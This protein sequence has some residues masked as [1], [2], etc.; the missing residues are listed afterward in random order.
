MEVPMRIVLTAALPALMTFPAAAGP[1]VPALARQLIH[2]GA[3][4]A[5]VGLYD[6]KAI[7]AVAGERIAGG[8]VTVETGDLWHIGSI[9]KSM[10]A[11]LAARM[12]ENGQIGWDSTLGDVLGP[13]VPGMDEGFRAAT[14]DQLLSHRAGVPENAGLVASMGFHGRRDG[15]DLI[16]ERLRYAGLV[17]HEAPLHPPGEGFLYSNAGYV[18]AG[19]MLEAADGRPW[20]DLIRAEVFEPLGLASAGFGP[21]GVAG[22]VDQPRGHAGGLFGGLSVREPG[23]SADN[24][25]VLGP[26]GTVHISLC[27]LLAYAAA[28]A[29]RPEGYLPPAAWDSLH[30]VRGDG[31]ALGWAIRDGGGRGHSG[32][33]TMWFAQVAIWPDAGRAAAVVTNDG[34]IDNIRGPVDK[35]VRQLAP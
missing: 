12:V 6:G 17:L 4:A 27:D 21:P 13:L 20:E 29:T 32:S 30:R 19:A 24:P 22:A 28:H 11:T 8:G 16:A 34:R 10:T 35:V 7:C 9:T 1:D 14:L 31:Y 23:P 5:G 15:A 18:V 2:A 26:A 25:A 33:N 3:P